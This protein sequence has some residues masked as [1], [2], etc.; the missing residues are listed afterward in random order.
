MICVFC[1]CAFNTF[2]RL[3]I[4]FTQAIQSGSAVRREAFKSEVCLGN[5]ILIAAKALTAE[6]GGESLKNLQK[7]Y[8]EDAT[9]SLSSGSAGEGGNAATLA[10]APPT[11]SFQ[12]HPHVC[13]H[14][15]VSLCAL[16]LS[17]S[18]AIVVFVVS[19]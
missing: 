1:M 17:V 10:S 12:K 9:R 2:D 3:L 5:S 14:L 19:W 15:S 16:F 11:G 4:D 8:G 6:D 13:L 7:R 18:V